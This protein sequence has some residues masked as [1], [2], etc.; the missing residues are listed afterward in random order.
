MAKN[1]PYESLTTS[2][3]LAI[4]EQSAEYA[5]KPDKQ[6]LVSEIWAVRGHC[7]ELRA[8]KIAKR[9]GLSLKWFD[10]TSFFKRG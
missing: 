9:S 7:D 2:P 8:K 3:H 4:G 1:K 5:Y 10:T 6:P